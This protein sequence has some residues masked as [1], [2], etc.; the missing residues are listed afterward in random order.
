MCGGGEGGGWLY[1]V[2]LL[3]HKRHKRSKTEICVS[4]RVLGGGGG[5]RSCLC[6]CVCVCVF[7]CVCVSALFSDKLCGRESIFPFHRST[8]EL[9]I[10]V[11]EVW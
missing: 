3:N 2:C 9:L 5:V 10:T 1:F 6:V 8:I 7:V 4:V 11:T